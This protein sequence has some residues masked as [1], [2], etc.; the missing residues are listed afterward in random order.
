MEE[1]VVYG[2]PAGEFNLV[3]INGQARRESHVSRHIFK[4]REGGCIAE[5]K[6][7]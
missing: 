3:F 7:E 6:D 5:E 4:E 2:F 1:V